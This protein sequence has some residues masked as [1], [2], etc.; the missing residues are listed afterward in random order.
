MSGV[1][2]QTPSILETKTVLTGQF[3]TTKDAIQKGLLEGKNRPATTTTAETQAMITEQVKGREA[4]NVRVFEWSNALF[5]TVV[6]NTVAPSEGK[7]ALQNNTR[8]LNRLA[9][10]IAATDIRDL[11][12]LE[13]F[14]AHVDN[15]V[16]DQDLHFADLP[17]SA[18]A[19][20]VRNP[21]NGRTRLISSFTDQL[22]V[23]I[24]E[25]AATQLDSFVRDRN[26]QHL[27]AMTDLINATPELRALYT[28]FLKENKPTLQKLLDRLKYL[29]LTKNLIVEGR[30]EYFV[31][32][33][34]KSAEFGRSTPEDRGRRSN[35]PI[36]NILTSGEKP[37]LQPLHSPITAESG[38]ITQPLKDTEVFQYIDSLMNSPQLLAIQD[39]FKD[40]PQVLNLIDWT[41][42]QA[43]VREYLPREAHVPPTRIISMEALTKIRDF[44]KEQS[45]DDGVVN[46]ASNDLSVWVDPETNRKFMVKHCPEQTL[47]ADYFGLEALQLVGVPIYEFYYG[48]M[49]DGSLTL[50]SG[51]LEG[52]HDSTSTVLLPENAPKQMKKA[53]LPERL[54]D[55]DYIQRSLLV[56]ILIGEY[57]SKA[58]NFMVLGDSV[59]HLDQGGCL[60]STASGKFKPFNEQLTIHEIQD[61]LYCYT[62]W[63]PNILEPVNQ[64]YANIVEIT[65]DKLVIKDVTKA[66]K[67]LNQLESLPQEK[68]TEALTQAGYQNGPE[69]IQRLTGWISRIKTELLPKYQNMPE[70]GRKQQYI[71]WAEQATTNFEQ[72]IAMGGE[73]NYYTRA[74]QTRRHTLLTLWQEAIHEAELQQ[75]V[76]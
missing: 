70:S 25:E 5:D 62:D 63:D 18:D 43:I 47:Q 1:D 38:E 56:E 26:I 51:F 11:P 73:L 45:S 37:N 48:R 10:N 22:T 75:N 16:L 20:T 32:G 66:Q 44:K 50:V 8:E 52:F 28:S 9:L 58:H 40:N 35:E 64:A 72:A 54:H 4:I 21:A 65:G 19:F 12:V 59:Q 14:H 61:V 69:S 76:R 49:P 7:A 36:K 17:S 42:R 23:Q 41:I 31:Q 34:V 74:I 30:A 3:P 13:F 24:S 39:R 67:L 57:N 60:T 55:S 15:P 6:Q 71:R 68:F 2:V 29:G 46:Q 33:L 53:R 27:D